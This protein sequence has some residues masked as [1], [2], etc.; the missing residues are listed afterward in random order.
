MLKT[1]RVALMAA[2]L[3]VS[4]AV[5]AF[6]QT[7][8]YPSKPITLIVPFPAGG[9]SDILAR[10]FA[11]AAQGIIS[12]P[13]QVVNRGGGS[14]TIANY[15]VVRSRPDGYTWL[16][17]STGHLSSTLHI[18]Q[19]QYDM[20]DFTVVNKVGE[21]VTALVVPKN[22]PY[23]SLEE[24]LA[25]ADESPGR[26]TIGNPGE[27]TVVTL[28]ALLLQNRTEAQLTNIPFQGSGPLLTAV[29]GGHVNSALMNVPEVRGQVGENG[30]LRAL[31]VLSEQRVDLMPDIPSSY[32]QGIQVGGGAGHFI[33]IPNNVPDEV[34]AEIDEL[35]RK[36][37]ES[38]KF[39]DATSAA[40]YQLGYKNSADARAELLE[41][42]E[43]TRE[44]Y[45][46]IG[47]I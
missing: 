41:W 25:A 27:G 8:S 34:V 22:S 21:M 2:V 16:W 9:V 46:Q 19:A 32:E 3:V 4:L 33:V 39:R 7:G 36:V 29:M 17:G 28:L 18:V 14:G 10:A 35:T 31:A 6:A 42:Y 15:E 43:V 5:G 23:Q 47:R 45:Q 26:I 40:G 30:L 24:Y 37:Y 11:D 13:I 38:E 1:F 12:Q 44:L 20:D